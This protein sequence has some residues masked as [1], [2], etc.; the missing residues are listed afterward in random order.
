MLVVALFGDSLV[1]VADV[2]V[3]EVGV[4]GVGVVDVGVVD[5]VVIFDGVVDLEVGEGGSEKK[6]EVY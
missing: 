5:V 3:L 6:D 1:G 4:V 2:G